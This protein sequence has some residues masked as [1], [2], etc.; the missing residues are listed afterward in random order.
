MSYFACDQTLSISTLNEWCVR[1][2]K[3][4]VHSYS[5]QNRHVSYILLPLFLSP[6]IH[7]HQNCKKDE[8]CFYLFVSDNNNNIAVGGGGV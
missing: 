8:S 5:T 6:S 2:Y 4:I 7:S 3:R 1:P